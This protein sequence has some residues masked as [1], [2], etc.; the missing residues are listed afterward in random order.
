MPSADEPWDPCSP[1]LE[2]HDC[3]NK[4][5][6]ANLELVWGLLLHLD[7]HKSMGP[8]GINPRVLKELVNQELSIIFQ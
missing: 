2:D 5:F 7:E 1:D 8:N 3:G 4:K 6:P